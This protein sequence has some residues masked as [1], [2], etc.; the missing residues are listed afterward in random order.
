M[1]PE[2]GAKACLGGRYR[3]EVTVALEGQVRSMEPEGRL[4]GKE[5]EEQE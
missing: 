2:E 4:G 3:P 1:Q 5:P